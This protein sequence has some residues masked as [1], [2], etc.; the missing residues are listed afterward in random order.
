MPYDLTPFLST[1]AAAKGYSKNTLAAYE[2]DLAHFL[3]A[4]GTQWGGF[5]DWAQV[6]PDMVEAYVAGLQTGPERYAA[7]TVARRVAAIRTFFSFLEQQGAIVRSPALRLSS[8]RVVKA[9][10]RT[11]TEAEMACLLAPAPAEAAP[12]TLRNAALLAVL[13]ATGLRVTEVV[14]LL[15]G[16]INWERYELACRGTARTRVLPL[17]SAGEPLRRY[18]FEG[19]PA[20]SHDSSGEVLF[21]NHRGQ[22]ITRQGVWLILKEAADQAGI[23]TDITPHTLRHSFACLLVNAGEDL[24]TVQNLLGHVNLS[25]TQVYKH[26]P[27]PTQEQ[28]L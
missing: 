1:L 24:R 22:R 19:R 18:V 11:L 25:T 5:M 15:L 7:S 17:N 21:L 26:L 10:P 6:T 27:T 3:T 13:C 12:K 2:N 14:N 16:D 4:L 23:A 9:V 8:P 28:T 20:L